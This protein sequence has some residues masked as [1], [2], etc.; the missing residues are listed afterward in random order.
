MSCPFSLLP[1][2]PSASHSAPRSGVGLFASHAIGV[3]PPRSTHRLSSSPATSPFAA[4]VGRP[5]LVEG[6]AV[7]DGYFM[8]T[9]STMVWVPSGCKTVAQACSLLRLVSRRLMLS[10]LDRLRPIQV[11]E[12]SP[13]IRSSAGSGRHCVHQSTFCAGRLHP[14]TTCLC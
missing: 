9:C 10:P 5:W 3:P 13:V 11:H 12:L 7:S 14:S 8:P 1:V 2:R 6:V 4:V